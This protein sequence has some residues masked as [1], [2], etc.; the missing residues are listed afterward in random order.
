MP[1]NNDRFARTVSEARERKNLS[2]DA[3]HAAGGPYR[4]RQAA[5]EKNEPGELTDSELAGYD[6]AHNWPAGYAKALAEIGEYECSGEPAAQTRRLSDLYGDDTPHVTTLGFEV[7]TDKPARVCGPVITNLPF[8]RLR[9]TI[10]ARSGIAII[11]TQIASPELVID[12]RAQHYYPTV[13]RKHGGRDAQPNYCIGT[14][15]D[16]SVATAV[17]ID[18]ISG[19]SSLTV[20]KRFAEALLR[21]RPYVRTTPTKAG[22][23]FLA[24]AAF[25]NDPE[26]EKSALLTLSNLRKIPITADVTSR[27][28]QFHAFYQQFI[29]PLNAGP[30]LAAP[31]PAAYDLLE[32]LV[33][34][35]D[36]M[37]DIALDWQKS[38]TYEQ[39]NIITTETILDQQEGIVFY[40]SSQAPELPVAL[41][42][43]W[44]P[45]TFTFYKLGDDPAARAGFRRPGS[46]LWPI[47]DMEDVDSSIGFTT[48]DNSTIFAHDTTKISTLTTYVGGQ[49][50]LSEPSRNARRIWIPDEI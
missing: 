21:V 6:R 36:N 1:K 3:I 35:R 43:A 33:T 8:H 29:E 41:T 7:G 26:Q 4:Q 14:K 23:T 16:S 24:L 34:A 20:A 9:G 17:A 46:T 18:P 42:F 32:G 27:N 28:A 5:I 30:D 48:A 12:T 44:R 10:A 40:D 19:L 22:L 25:D 31:D 37:F 38:A 2:Q 50:I 39:P 45:V 13:P 15:A 47:F 49:A 11:D